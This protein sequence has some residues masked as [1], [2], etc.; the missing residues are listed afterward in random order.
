MACTRNSIL[1]AA[2]AGQLIISFAGCDGA[3]AAD[4]NLAL[5]LLKLSIECP[6]KPIKQL[7]AVSLYVYRVERLEDDVSILQHYVSASS[8]VPAIST[9]LTVTFNFRSIGEV[10]TIKF[11]PPEFVAWIRC[12]NEERCLDL[13][14]NTTDGEM[15]FH[16][17]DRRSRD[18]FVKAIKILSNIP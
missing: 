2:F 7:D 12:K 9:Y 14:N 3:F 15:E 16:F 17:C 13:K 18:N 8:V 4:R 10:G 11:D 5:E 1:R 6:Q